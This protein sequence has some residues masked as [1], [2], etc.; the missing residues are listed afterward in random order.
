MELY[1]NTS[2]RI[3]Q[4]VMRAYSTSFSSSSSLFHRSIRADIYN[5][6]AL[7]RIADEIVDTYQG[8]DSLKL[9]DDLE[10]ETLAAM[11]REYSTNPVVHAF[12]ITARTFAINAGYITAFFTSMRMDITPTTYTPTLYQTYIYG[13]AEVI[14]LMCLA[15]FCGD[16][17]QAFTSLSRGARYLGAAYQKINFLRDLSADS[18]DLGRLYFPG[19]TIDSFDE[20]A[21]QAVINDIEHDISKAQESITKLPRSAHRATRLS[22][23]Y[24]MA[25]LHKLRA[26]PVATIKS[27]RVRINNVHKFWLYIRARSE[28][29]I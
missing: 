14:G 28:V 2:Q 29:R 4:V 22:W 8:D 9:L 10:S 3:S 27:K 5:I 11:T 18:R 24:Y 26:C 6:Y 19:Y 21:K 13:S 12:G 25:L 1:S 17:K 20:S 23:L 7:V 16:D 15:V